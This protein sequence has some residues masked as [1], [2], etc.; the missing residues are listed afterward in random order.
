MARRQIRLK[1]PALPSGPQACLCTAA[2]VQTCERELALLHGTQRAC[3]H[4]VENMHCLPCL[5]N[6]HTRPVAFILSE[7]L[8]FHALHALAQPVPLCWQQFGEASEADS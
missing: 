7:S 6:G 5:A 8:M 1:L 2:C 3:A 4:E